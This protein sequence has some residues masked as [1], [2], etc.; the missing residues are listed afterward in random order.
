[1]RLIA[2]LFT[3]SPADSLLNYVKNFPNP[4]APEGLKF[5]GPLA[6]IFCCELHE[7]QHPY[8]AFDPDG[9]RLWDDFI[10]FHP[11]SK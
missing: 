10:S 5:R 6:N 11:P 8:F 4:A 7:A 3:V 1:M 9:K 2:V